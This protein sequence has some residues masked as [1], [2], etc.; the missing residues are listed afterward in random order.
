MVSPVLVVAMALELG[1]GRRLVCCP[2]P[3]LIGRDSY[4]GDATPA[5]YETM[6]GAAAASDTPILGGTPVLGDTPVLGAQP[7]PRVLEPAASKVA[8][9]TASGPTPTGAAAD[10]DTPVLLW[11]PGAGQLPENELL[12]RLANAL[13]GVGARMVLTSAAYADAAAT[14]DQLHT[15]GA[16]V[17]AR[18]GA[19]L[20]LDAVLGAAPGSQ[21][22]TGVSLSAAAP[23]I[24]S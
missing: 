21:S 17:R 8:D 2:Q 20:G 9:P 18:A 12:R 1:G 22:S 19:G 10:S 23:S 15:A 6:E 7:L 5:L 3:A 16:V 11:L 14:L 4:E 24:V 13:H